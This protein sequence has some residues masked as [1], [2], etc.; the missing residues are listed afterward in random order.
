MTSVGERLQYLREKQLKQ[1]REKFIEG[2][3]ISPRTL[4]SYEKNETSPGTDFL[5]KVWDKYHA[6]LSLDDFNWLLFGERGQG[7]PAGDYARVPLYDVQ[8]AA[9]AGAVV[10]G[11]EVL[12]VLA[13][14]KS[15]LSS[16]LRVSEKDLA[17]IFVSGES[18]EPT[19]RPG[20]MA[21]IVKQDGQPV[22]DGIYVVRLE[23]ALLVKRLQRLPGGR[24]QVS[25][26]NPAYKP[27]EIDLK[28]QARDFAIIGKVVWAGKRF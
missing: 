24:L 23:D 5:Q 2:L 26:D 21:L 6:Q 8:A 12:D 19:L 25:S 7:L 1:S 14:K 18:M 9:G 3:E 22:D 17:L 27:F 4:S 28:T 13:F 16:E 11:E 15:W 20:D 10:S